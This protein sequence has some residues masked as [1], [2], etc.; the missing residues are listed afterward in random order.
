MTE[1][2]G[3][4]EAEGGDAAWRDFNTAPTHPQQVAGRLARE[5]QQPVISHETSS[6]IPD[7]W[8]SGIYRVFSVL[9]LRF[10]EI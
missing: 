9:S 3:R 2:K 6:V 1:G 5:R 8:R 4:D 7:P 10:I